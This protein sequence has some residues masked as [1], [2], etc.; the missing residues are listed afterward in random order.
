MKTLIGKVTAILFT[1][2]ILFG[3]YGAAE[4]K[5]TVVKKK[6]TV[7]LI[8]ADWC[9]ACQKVDPIIK[10]LRKDYGSKMNFVVLDVTDEASE[11][12]SAR[13]AKRNGLSSFFKKNKRKTSTVAV[14]NKKGKVFHTAKNYSRSA[15]V[16]AFKKALK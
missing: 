2:T 9:G 7:V 8:K 14:F 16:R 1:F 11:A 4:A 15:Y 5:T 13:I 3:S 6:P 12:R 10:S